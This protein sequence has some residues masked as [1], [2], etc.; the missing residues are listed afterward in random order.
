MKRTLPAWVLAGLLACLSWAPPTGAEE[1]GADLRAQI[2]ALKQNQEQ[3][4]QQMQIYQ[5]IQALKQGQQEIQKQLQAIEK[6]VR[7]RPEGGPAAP[8]VKDVVVDL[9]DNLTKGSPSAKLALLEFTDYQCP[10]CS[11]HVKETQP[12]IEKEFIDTGKLLYAMLDM[13]LESIHKQAFKAAE[14]SHCAGEQGKFWEMHDRL[15]ENQRSL[16]PFAPHA[17]AIGLDVAKFDECMASG[18]QAEAIRKDMAQAQKV[19][20]TGT[21]GFLLART[22]PSDPKKVRGISVLRGAQPFDAFKAAIESAL[23]EVGD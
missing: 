21:P 12:K 5:D 22:D 14:A 4:K 7:T 23:K 20:V 19:G 16:E 11:R 13:P 3:M 2:E 6:L 10:F 8:N 9:G 15:F 17:T 1:T 18:R